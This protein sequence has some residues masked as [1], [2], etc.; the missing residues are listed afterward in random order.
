[1][2]NILTNYYNTSYPQY[3]QY[4][5]RLI[6]NINKSYPHYP[7]LYNKQQKALKRVKIHNVSN[8]TQNMRKCI[9]SEN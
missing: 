1:M 5:H 2:L 9:L 7:Q 3:P 4:P 6:H 8:N